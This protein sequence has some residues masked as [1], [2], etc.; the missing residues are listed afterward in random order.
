MK[1][2]LLKLATLLFWYWAAYLLWN[3]HIGILSYV[4]QIALVVLGLHVLEVAA[5]WFIW[6][7]KSDWPRLDALQVLVF[8]AFHLQK[9]ISKKERVGQVG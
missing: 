8:G 3:G 2:I 9:F 7:S 4:P 5:F 6:R 1:N